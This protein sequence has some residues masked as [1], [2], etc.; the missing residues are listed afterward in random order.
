MTATE[1]IDWYSDTPIAQ[2][3]DDSL[4]RGE[5]LNRLESVL[6]RLHGTGRSSVLALIGS[7]GSGKSSVLEQLTERLA[8][9]PADAQ[10]WVKVDFNP[11]YYQDL[12]SLQTGFFR[13]LHSALPSGPSWRK[14]RDAIA[15]LGK[16]VAPL[17]GLLS[18]VGVDASG[19]LDGLAAMIE[20]DKGVVSQQKAAETALQKMG[21][22]VLVVMDD[23]DRLDPPELLLLFKLIRLVG[24]LPN[25]HYLLAY[26]ERTLLE[27]LGRTG[28][29]GRDDPRRAIDY[30]E[31]IVQVRLDVPPVRDEQLS[32]WVDASLTQLAREHDV[33]LTD[34][35]NHRFSN[36]YFGHL[37]KRLDTPRAVKRYFAQV[38]SFLAGVVQEVDLV[39]FLV[40]NWLRSAEPLLY[41]AIISHRAQL[42]GDFSVRS[43]EWIVG[44]RDPEAERAYWE[45]VLN[46][47]RV[48]PEHMEGVANLIGQLFPRFSHQWTKQSYPY[49]GSNIAPTRV[50]HSDYFD[51]Y[52]AFAVPS[53]DL[54]DKVVHAA[55]QQIVSGSPGEELNIIEEVLPDRAALILA[56]LESWSIPGSAESVEIISWLTKNFHRLPQHVSIADAQQRAKWFGCRLYVRLNDSQQMRVL[57]QAQ[58]ATQGLRYFSFLSNAAASEFRDAQMK[59]AEEATPSKADL[60]FAELIST[61]FE[62]Q[63]DA[64]TPL[65]ID[66]D[67]WT[68]IWDWIRIDL[69]A[70]KAWVTR[71]LQQ[72]K[73]SP[74]DLAGRFLSTLIPLGVKNPIP[75]IGDFDA[76]SFTQLVDLEQLEKDLRL[77]PEDAAIPLEYE[78]PATDENRRLVARKRLAQLFASRTSEKE[79]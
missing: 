69:P 19:A 39:D 36:A 10:Q 49:S 75:K 14:A 70:A 43:E 4:D 76:V 38:D 44:K 72:Y 67:V 3:E 41:R 34:E 55:Y 22:P 78:T 79:S 2:Y 35:V 60:G 53:E 13:E 21:K 57:E 25:V 54:P 29:V 45:K 65:E 6:E 8:K 66:D 71:G 30:L 32:R 26:D 23:V 28:L 63:G 18:A 47:A 56:K 77:S 42:L 11:W 17:G 74:L 5:F 40:V 50:A 51:R 68:L 20:S 16:S 33:E 27:A 64:S 31:K 61:A 1:P 62:G 9:K 59:S 24:R 12:V 46:D 48:A 73:W 7:W 37:Q 58:Q 15:G 52:F